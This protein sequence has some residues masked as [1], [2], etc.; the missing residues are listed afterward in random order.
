MEPPT[1]MFGKVRLDL[2]ILLMIYYSIYV[3]GDIATTYWLILNDPYGI[4]H[5]GNP[6]GR[7][8][9]LSQGL[10]GLLI[11]KLMT[12]IPLSAMVI[13]FETKYRNLKWFRE[14]TE[15]VTLGLI[16]YSLILF[17]NNFAAIIVTTFFNGQLLQLYPTIKVLILIL[18][19]S[20]IIVLLRIHGHGNLLTI[21]EVVLGTAI[22]I[23]PIL[24][25]DPLFQHLGQNLWFSMVYLASMLTIVGIFF[26]ITDEI[27]KERKRKSNI[28][29]TR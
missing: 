16:T 20:L 21:S 27:I 19:T 29:P 10:A 9:Y 12:F 23:G 13:I 25:F 2:I 3:V 6:I 7:A 28:K 11:G 4:L 14:T 22:T 15:T 26:Y 5:E 17:L 18:S 1:K 8:L 24:L